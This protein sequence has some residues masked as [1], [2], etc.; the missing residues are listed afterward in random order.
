MQRFKPH[1][2][3]GYKSRANDD[4]ALVKQVKQFTGSPFQIIRRTN[5]QFSRSGDSH[6]PKNM[7][8]YSLTPPKWDGE[9]SRSSYGLGVTHRLP[10]PGMGRTQ[11]RLQALWLTILA[12]HQDLSGSNPHDYAS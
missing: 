6:R 1:G 4:R 7:W 8:R 2:L 11:Q 3:K 10:V 5:G 9:R 12:E